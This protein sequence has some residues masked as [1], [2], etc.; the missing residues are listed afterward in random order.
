MTRIHEALTKAGQEHPAAQASDSL[1]LLDSTRPIEPESKDSGIG[2]PRRV[3]VLTPAAAVPLEVDDLRKRCSSPKW[4]LD[5]AV[6]VFSDPGLS[7]L[8]AEQF[9][10]LRSRL[11]QLRANRPL[12]TILITSAVAGEGKTFVAFNLA[13]AIVR[14]PDQRVLIVDAD[15][16]CSRLHRIFGA[17]IA[18]GLSDYLGGRADELAI[19][20]SGQ[21]GNLYLI[22]S[23]TRTANPSELLANGRFKKLMERV[24]P[25]FDWIIVDSTPCLPVTDAQIA[26]YSCDGLLLVV[27]AY[28]TPAEIAQR[29]RQE[30][31]DR[32]VLGV[33]FNSVQESV[34]TY[35]SYYNY[36]QDGHDEVKKAQPDR[37]S[38]RQ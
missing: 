23:G 15:L 7:A 2:L 10:T 19:I 6:D 25:L 12:R 26:A 36:P 37:N 9:R 27:K 32:N 35:G 24:A 18:L 17:P 3:N 28:S 30:L 20:Q 33:V 22:P 13:Q 29:A 11:C 4:S 5:P 1:F 16:R 14:Q 38:F 8:G 31:Q 21:E 34:L